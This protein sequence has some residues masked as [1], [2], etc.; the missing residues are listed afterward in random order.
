[1]TDL[2]HITPDLQSLAKPIS[3]LVQDPANARVHPERNLVALRASLANFTQRKNV[4]VQRK[5]D[6]TRV[7]RAGNGTLEVARIMGWTHLAWVEI[8]EDDVQ[9]TAYAIADNR[10]ADLAEWD[11]STLASLLQS[12]KAEGVQLEQVGYQEDELKALLETLSM[13]ADADWADAFENAGNTDTV[14][15]LAQITFVLPKDTVEDL[16]QHLKNYDT[17]DKNK[18]MCLWLS[19]AVHPTLHEGPVADP[20]AA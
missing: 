18:A 8:E 17:A 6:G 12:I 7:V 16:K 20:N 10:T 11:N 3:E 9:A 1:M 15:N 14:D 4:V 19:E 5:K 13:P 2:S